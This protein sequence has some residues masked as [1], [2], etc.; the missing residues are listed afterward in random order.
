MNEIIAAKEMYLTLK[1][2]HVTLADINNEQPK[3]IRKERLA[4]EKIH[5]IQMLKEREL[6]KNA[7]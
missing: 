3:G 5:A 4:L 1:V 2:E 7:M 6:Q